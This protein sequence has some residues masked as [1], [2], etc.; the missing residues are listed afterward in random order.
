MDFIDNY[1]KEEKKGEEMVEEMKVEI[2]KPSKPIKQ[3]SEQDTINRLQR[4]LSQS[5][6]NCPPF[7]VSDSIK[8]LIEVVPPLN[9]QKLIAD[10]KL[11]LYK[12]KST[13]IAGGNTF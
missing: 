11:K 7:E 9:I 3:I 1:M 12:D 13:I 4:E 10:K 8:P 6:I 2:E 5:L